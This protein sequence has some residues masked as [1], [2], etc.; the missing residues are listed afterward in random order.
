[1]YLLKPNGNGYGNGNGNGNGKG[2]GYRDG[3]G[4]GDG[5]G[6]WDGEGG[7]NWYDNAWDGLGHLYD[8]DPFPPEHVICMIA[9]RQLIRGETHEGNI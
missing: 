2:Y 6:N 9:T 7:G 4:Y 8:A 3:D 1:V 5:Y